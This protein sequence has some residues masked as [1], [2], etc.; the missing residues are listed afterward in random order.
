MR[1]YMALNRQHKVDKK[2]IRQLCFLETN[3]P[4]IINS[5]TKLQT[6]ELKMFFNRVQMLFDVSP[7]NVELLIK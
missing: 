1:I 5:Q 2:Y 4:A 7:Y 6:D 3:I